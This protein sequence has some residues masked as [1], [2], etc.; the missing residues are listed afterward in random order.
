[1][2]ERA[3]NCATF[4]VADNQDMS[5]RDTANE[6]NRGL[7]TGKGR[8]L[9]RFVGTLAVAGLLVAA[10]PLAASGWEDND[11]GILARIAALE[12]QVE[13]LQDQVSALQA[14]NTALHKQLATIQSNHALLLGPFVNVDPNPEVGVIGPNIIFSGANIHILSG[15]GRTDDN[16][17][18]TGLGNLII[19]YD[20]DPFGLPNVP[21]F[22]HPPGAPPLKPGDRG[23]S[24]NLVIGS[25]NRFSA[26]GGFVAGYLNS[27]RNAATG[28][29][30]GSGNVASGFVASVSGGQFNQA[31]GTLCSVSGGESNSADI[32]AASV[33]GGVFCHASGFFASVLGGVDNTASQ[34]EGS[35]VLGGDNNTA[36]G[37]A[38]VVLGGQNVTD[39]KGL[40]IAP[41]PPFP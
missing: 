11:K 33:S 37:F 3:L 29:S 20:E 8:S 7:R 14:S 24:H 16:G 35:V 36:G 30:G 38:S 12:A 21:G 23:G 13:A 39:N 40:S 9:W 17:N 18:A 2:E 28:V 34:G 31:S 1:M 15:S 22:G 10:A 4:E 41:Q 27:I 5:D 26:L 19:G 6:T 25:G 32:F